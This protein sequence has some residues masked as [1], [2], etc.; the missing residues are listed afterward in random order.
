MRRKHTTYAALLPAPSGDLNAFQ[1]ENMEETFSRAIQSIWVRVTLVVVLAIALVF[2]F[3][4]SPSE[5]RA[6]S[7]K[8][9]YFAGFY[10]PAIMLGAVAGWLFLSRRIWWQATAWFLAAT[11]LLN[12]WL[13]WYRW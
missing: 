12:L 6:V 7:L 2:F 8:V 9:S 13:F 3:G 10:A 4:L 1:E 11:A 5:Q